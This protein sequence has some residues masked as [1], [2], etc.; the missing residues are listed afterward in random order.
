M[1]ILSGVIETDPIITGIHHSDNEGVGDWNIENETE[2]NRD[3]NEKG[4]ENEEN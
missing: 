4:Q 2:G 1:G 3:D